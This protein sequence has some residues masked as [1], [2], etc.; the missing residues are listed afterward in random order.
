[1]DRQKNILNYLTDKIFH[2]KIPKQGIAILVLAGFVVIGMAAVRPPYRA[3]R[4]LKVLPKNISDQTLDKVMDEFCKAL[5]VECNYCHVQSPTDS[6]QWD[7]ASDDKPE[8]NIARKMITM[9]NKINKDFFKATTK[10]GDENALLEI[11][12]MTCHRG[13][14]HPEMEEETDSTATPQ[15]ADS[16]AKKQ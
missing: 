2:M 3:G 1:M 13:D 6:T 12:C 15:A 4:N 10:Y 7:M 14:P 5:N 9:S 16:T 8:K 11:R